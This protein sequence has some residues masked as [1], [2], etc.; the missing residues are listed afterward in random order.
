MDLTTSYQDQG[1]PAHGTLRVERGIIA[2]LAERRNPAIGFV[3]FER[4]AFKAL[5]ADEAWR[6]ATAPT[7]PE[8]ERELATVWKRRAWAMQGRIRRR[9]TWRRPAPPAAPREPFG[10][11]EILFLPG[12][13]DRHDF[14]HLAELKQRTRLALTFLFYDLLSVL[15]DDDPRLLQADPTGLPQSEFIAREAA[16]VLTI[17]RFSAGELRGF[18]GRRASSSPPVVPIR[19]AGRL[20]SA[21]RAA[22]VPG[23]APGRFVLSVG[24]VVHRKNH[25]L[26][27][28][29]WASLAAKSVALPTLVIV[30][31]IDLEG[32]GLVRSVKRDKVLRET[33][34][35]M[36]NV[37]D[38]ALLWLYQ[39]CRY[40]VF[41]SLL[42]G[43]G[44]PV[45]ESLSHGKVCLASSA[46]AIPEAGQGAALTLS[47]ADAA[48]WATEVA[49]LNDD[50][51][52]ATEAARVARLFRPIT[53]SD[54]ASDI[55]EA[56]AR[57]WSPR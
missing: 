10:P 29:V 32:N 7:R 44:L 28:Q 21:A 25:A 38:G 16:L 1:R 15:A 43:F 46:A 13:H 41:P 53:W 36:P 40:T 24:D 49:R 14:A 9:L 47:P 12:E 22:P 54:T 3:A 57:V 4:G 52:L 56:I 8:R 51:A 5:S 33:V 55:L 42:E 19:L 18:L 48:A 31:R 20:P 26:L 27:V 17:S 34:R 45:A 50:S 39:H 35:F 2:A 30:G 6:I 37:D 11:D 23:L